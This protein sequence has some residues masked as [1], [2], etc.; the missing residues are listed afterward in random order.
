M[1]GE[2]ETWKEGG[3]G[4]REKIDLPDLAAL[5]AMLDNVL[6]IDDDAR[7]CTC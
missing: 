3:R 7:V 1:E 5:H 6:L 4:K 2:R